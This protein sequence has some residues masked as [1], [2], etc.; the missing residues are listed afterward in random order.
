MCNRRQADGVDDLLAFFEALHEIGAI[1]GRVPGLHADAQFTKHS[2]ASAELH[3]CVLRGEAQALRTYLTSTLADAYWL[4]IGTWRQT[5]RAT[6]AL[7][8]HDRRSGTQITLR[9]SDN[10]PPISA[11]DLPGDSP[12]PYRPGTV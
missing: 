11:G 9:V 10:A 12:R 2:P 7:S 3:Y 4:E 5:A 6:M 1:L 8:V